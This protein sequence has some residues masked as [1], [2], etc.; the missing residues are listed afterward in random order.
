MSI[1]TR[2]QFDKS[3]LA[4]IEARSVAKSQRRA[5][6]RKMV[7]ECG[8]ERERRALDLALGGYGIE[9]IHVRTG[10]DI[11]LVAALVTGDA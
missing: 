4:F 9:H 5:L 2:S 7:A 1:D 8:S 10:V 3:D 6:A 11:Q